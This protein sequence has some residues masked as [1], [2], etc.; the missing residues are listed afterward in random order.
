[1]EHS[2]GKNP[3]N[4]QGDPT[5]NGQQA[6]IFITSTNDIMFLPWSFLFISGSL[7]K[8]FKWFSRNL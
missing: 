6:V 2:Y 8:D 7:Q 3:L 1:M 5:Q 4:L